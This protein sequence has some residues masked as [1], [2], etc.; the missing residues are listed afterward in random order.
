MISL[1]F[2]RKFEVKGI[3]RLFLAYGIVNFLISNIVLQIA[4]LLIPTLFATFL[5]QLVNLL[6]GYNLYGKKV[7]KL[8]KLNNLILKKYFFISIISLTLNYI[9]IE[10]FFYYGINKNL[11]AILLIPLLVCFSFFSQK[12]Y[13]FKK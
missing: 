10:S 8:E 11:S 3:K 1:K 12:F 5:S 2:K 9:F 6:V 4:L 13:V 7:F